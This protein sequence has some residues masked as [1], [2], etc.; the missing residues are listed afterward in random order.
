[1]TK[2]WAILL[3]AAQDEKWIMDDR[4]RIDPPTMQDKFPRI[5]LGG[6]RYKFSAINF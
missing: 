1:M 5:Y 4:R 3:G 2:K 6:S